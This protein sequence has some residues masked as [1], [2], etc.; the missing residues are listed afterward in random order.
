MRERA[1]CVSV[2][3]AFNFG[4]SGLRLISLHRKS[5]ITV[6]IACSQPGVYQ[7]LLQNRGKSYFHRIKSLC[8]SPFTTEII[9]VK[10]VLALFA[11]NLPLKV[12][13]FG[14]RKYPIAQANY[15]REDFVAN[16]SK[17]EKSP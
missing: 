14:T 7:V 16:Q 2:R 5:D 9:C 17:L 1:V 15:E 8:A 13:A 4:D 3:D 6:T 11:R 12:M 10:R